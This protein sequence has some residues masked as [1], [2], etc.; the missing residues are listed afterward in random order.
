MTM[1]GALCLYISG[2]C[3]FSLVLRDHCKTFQMRAELYQLFEKILCIRLCWDS[4]L[5][6]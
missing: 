4:F 2:T 5:Q 3:N 6:L 1:E